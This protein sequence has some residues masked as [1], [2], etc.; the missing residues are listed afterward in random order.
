MVDRD[1]SPSGDIAG[2]PFNGTVC[3]PNHVCAPVGCTSDADCSG[4][5]ARSSAPPQRDERVIS[6]HELSL[7]GVSP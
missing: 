6:D 5:G 3:G 2:Q 1:C 7:T 4:T